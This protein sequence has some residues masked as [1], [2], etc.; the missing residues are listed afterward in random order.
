M[1]A[2]GYFGRPLVVDVTSGTSRTRPLPDGVLRGYLTVTGTVSMGAEPESA[3]TPGGAIAMPTGGV[4]PAGV[5]S[6]LMHAKPVVMIFSTG[7]EVVPAGK[8]ELKPGQ[9]SGWSAAVW[10]RP[11]NRRRGPGCPGISRRRPDGSTRA[12]R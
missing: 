6:V 9:S 2:G 7:D 11:R 5:T 3:V 4:I 12:V 8:P 10:R 1:P